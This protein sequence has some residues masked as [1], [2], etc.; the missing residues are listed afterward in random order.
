MLTDLLDTAVLPLAHAGAGA[1]WQALLTLLS[2]GLVLVVVLVVA[3]FVAIDEPGDLILPLAAVAVLAGFSGALSNTLSDWVGWAFPIGVVAV[4]ALLVH[5]LT[6]QS[7]T[8]TSPLTIVAVALAVIG[9]F[10]LEQP[11]R[12]AWH[13]S[14]VGLASAP[15]DDL[16]VE[17]VEPEPDTTVAPGPVTVTVEVTG[18][19]LGEGFNTTGA[20]AEDPEELVG[21]TLTAVSLET[22]E[23][24]SAAGD[25]KEDCVDG[26]TRATFE[27]PVGESGEWSIFVEAKTSDVRPFVTTGQSTGQVTD[28]VTVTVEGG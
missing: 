9:A 28:S 22:G 16:S 21:I 24:T 23:S 10:T 18:G 15:L 11:I 19:T 1:T 2:L 4:V 8:A 17:I 13:P 26:C 27:I 7:L 3:R 12:I 14:T 25:P 20:R 6:S 5:A